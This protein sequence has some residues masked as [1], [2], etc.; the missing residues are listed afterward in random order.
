MFRLRVK[1][2]LVRKGLSISKF[3]RGADIPIGMARR[4]VNDPSYNPTGATLA[5]AARYLEVSMDDLW[6]DDEEDV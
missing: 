3:S 6:Y 5:K 2:I 4:M 1:E